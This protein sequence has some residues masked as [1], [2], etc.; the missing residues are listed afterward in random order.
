M[1]RPR[2]FL[3]LIHNTLVCTFV[4]YDIRAQAFRNQ[5][6]R[7]IDSVIFDKRRAVKMHLR[8]VYIG[9]I[10]VYKKN[11]FGIAL[12]NGDL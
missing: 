2:I 7:C 8:I 1:H 11:D 3:V 9:D 12:C 4:P 6:K 5:P 10:G